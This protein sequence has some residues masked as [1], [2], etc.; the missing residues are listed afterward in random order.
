MQQLSLYF[1]IKTLSFYRLCREIP[2]L[3]GLLLLG[4]FVGVGYVLFAYKEEPAAMVYLYCLVGFVLLGR[5][6]CGASPKEEVL[7]RGLRLPVLKIQLFKYALLSVPFWML[8]VGIG[9]FVLTAGSLLLIMLSRVRGFSGWVVPSGYRPEAYQW[10]AVWRGEGIWLFLSGIFLMGEGMANG[11]ERLV[12]FAVI[13]TVC[14]PCFL[15]YYKRQDPV[16]FLAVYRNVAVLLKRKI[17]ELLLNSLLAVAI[18]LALIGVFSP[19]LL[20]ASM[21]MAGG[22]LLTN[23]ILAYVYYISYPSILQAG[24]SML[25]ITI[26]MVA[27]LVDAPL[28]YWFF[29]L[30][31]FPI[32]HFIAYQNLKST[33][34]ATSKD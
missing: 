25:C 21:W 11:N 9:F 34:Y 14:L 20:A 18:C 19:S 15:S 5:W 27:L 28:Y 17:T 3:V 26:V 33:L 31:V 23:L 29:I 16:T 12:H 13:W 32:L 10:L 1:K 24:I 2:V 6:L 4:V 8:N 30:P 22:G 7:I